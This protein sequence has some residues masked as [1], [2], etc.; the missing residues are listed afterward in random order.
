MYVYPRKQQSSSIT[1]KIH[2][3]SRSQYVRPGKQILL[4]Q[5]QPNFLRSASLPYKILPTN[6]VAC[7]QPFSLFIHHIG[8]ETVYYEALFLP[9]RHWTERTISQ[10][11]KTNCTL[12]SDMQYSVRSKHAWAVQ[13]ISKITQYMASRFSLLTSAKFVV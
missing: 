6:V 3:G 7:N 2:N 9:Y 11:C 1:F 5:I 12:C 13:K 4:N 10:F 8:G